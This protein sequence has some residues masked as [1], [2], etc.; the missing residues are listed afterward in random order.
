MVDLIRRS[1]V[2]KFSNRFTPTYLKKLLPLPDVNVWEKFSAF[3]SEMAEWIRSVSP[4]GKSEL[5]EFSPSCDLGE[6]GDCYVLCFDIPGVRKVDLRVT[7]EGNRLTV[8]GQR[9]TASNE[10]ARSV[11]QYFLAENSRGAFARSFTFPEPLGDE[12]VCAS[13]ANGV[14][15][16]RVAKTQSNSESLVEID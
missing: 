9:R 1:T 3:E 11:D 5:L 2:L 8:S 4:P 10:L 7:L 15:T 14:L 16:I 12:N 6:C 13:Y